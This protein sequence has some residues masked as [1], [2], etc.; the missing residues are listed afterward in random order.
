MLYCNRIVSVSVSVKNCHGHSCGHD[1]PKERYVLNMYSCIVLY[2]CIGTNYGE[3]KRGTTR[4]QNIHQSK[5]SFRAGESDAYWKRARTGT[6]FSTRERKEAEGEDQQSLVLQSPK[7]PDDN[8]FDEIWAPVVKNFLVKNEREAK[9]ST[10]EKTGQA[11]KKTPGNPKKQKTDSPA[12]GS[13]SGLASLASSSTAPTGSCDNKKVMNHKGRAS[14][15]ACS[16]RVALEM[17]QLLRNFSDAQLFSTPY[18]DA[19]VGVRERAKNKRANR[20][21]VRTQW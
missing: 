14:A 1:T 10:S 13:A 2:A 15:F 5:D 16:E 9:E 3:D 6:M 18:S 7:K 19:G 8:F 11:G 4:K 17:Q 12:K 20:E 21:I